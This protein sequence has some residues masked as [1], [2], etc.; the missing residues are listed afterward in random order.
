MTQT[1]VLDAQFGPFI[2]ALA[3]MPALS[4]RTPADA[5]AMWD[6]AVYGTPEPVAHVRSLAIPVAGTSVAARLYAPETRPTALIV[7]YHGGG[8]VLGSLE[9]HDLPLRA[10]VNQ[11]GAAILS[12]DYR[13]APEYPFP[14]GL[15]DCYAALVW[16]KERQA[17][18]T[19]GTG[20]LLVAGDSA[21]GNLAGV[22]ALLA[23]D[24]KGPK[25]DCQLLIYPVIDGR[26]DT[27]SYTQRA[28]GGLLTSQDMRWF[29]NQ[30]IA[31]P[32]KRLDPYASPC[33][34]NR[35]S[36]LPPAIVVI[37]EFDPLRDEGASY[38][39]QLRGAG[40][41]V[42]VLRYA[43]LPHFFFNTLYLVK[44]AGEAFRE[45]AQHVCRAID[46]AGGRT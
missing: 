38:A 3:Q 24:R 18:L 22:V 1:P 39:E 19:G 11:T 15:E 35:H 27:P 8:W 9:T 33:M 41:D 4:S 21:G 17:E 10:L 6:A 30:Y 14:S 36:D 46:A 31:D 26:C 12:V 43:T 45:M 7:Y 32:P 37:A 44:A 29:W 25:I 40:N 2:E 20:P 42:T 13:L 16:A 34:A 28:Q 23:R 5:R